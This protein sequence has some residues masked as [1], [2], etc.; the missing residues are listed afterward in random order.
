MSAL[1]LQIFGVP[2]AG[3]RLSPT[4]VEASDDFAAAMVEAEA[5]GFAAKGAPRDEVPLP[6]PVRLVAPPMILMGRMPASAM[7][8]QPQTPQVQGADVGSQPDDL[9]VATLP[10][11][12]PQPEVLPAA[13]ALPQ[14]TSPGRLPS[15]DASAL[16]AAALSDSMPS[17]EP[18]Q[19]HLAASQIAESPMDAR[20]LQDR[21]IA[22]GQAFVRGLPD[23]GVSTAAPPK[24]RAGGQADPSA[25]PVSDAEPDPAA[26]QPLGDGVQPQE[27]QAAPTLAKTAAPALAKV[28]AMPGMIVASGAD[29]VDLARRDTDSLTPEPVS[30]QPLMPPKQA[31]TAAIAAALV[32][33]RPPTQVQTSDTDG[34]PPMPEPTAR[35]EAA[36]LTPLRKMSVT[37]SNSPIVPEARSYDAHVPDVMP[38]G[39]QKSAHILQPVAGSSAESAWQTR[40]QLQRQ[41]E[42]MRQVVQTA[43]PQDATL[44]QGGSGAITP[45]ILP[46]DALALRPPLQPLP[47]PALSQTAETTHLV[48]AK[49][50]GDPTAAQAML[51]D[52]KLDAALLPNLAAPGSTPSR[53]P[54]GAAHPMV[55]PTV[56]V[57]KLAA[58]IVPL[59][60][61][62][63]AGPVEVLLHPEELGSVRFQIHQH[64]DSVRVVLCVERP[65]TLDL[66]RR[67]A[68]QLMQEF[69]QAGFS[70]A[71]LS[72]G[73]WAQQGGQP[74]TPSPPPAMLRPEDLSFIAPAATRAATVSAAQ[75]GGH[76]L[77]LRL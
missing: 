73:S 61:R 75:Y 4:D 59:A 50:I 10:S 41:P 30:D 37:V 46:D 19:E 16:P 65:E 71:T 67:H 20:G 5:V 68:D 43:L 8:E 18:Q 32:Q 47:A 72:F 14:F 34:V 48:K 3:Q 31:Q 17:P 53:V 55:L 15:A 13:A 51:N 70:G 69:R 40:I 60:Q 35:S 7:P 54:D 29:M 39:A 26:H 9:P 12:A 36:Q 57:P 42:A 11:Q 28:S 1:T 23:L 76:G 64:G 27:R 6:D 38:A 49:A 74:D 33:L 58:Q 45:T 22:L 62:A 63:E 24:W 44:P 52:A 2:A 56:L 66:V 77:N 21:P 25:V